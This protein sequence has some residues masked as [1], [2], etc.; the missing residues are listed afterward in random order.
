MN[1]LDDILVLCLRSREYKDP[2]HVQFF[3]KISIQMY[4]LYKVDSY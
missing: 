3:L 2:I 1:F 4:F